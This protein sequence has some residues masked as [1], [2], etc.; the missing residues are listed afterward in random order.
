VISTLLDRLIYAL[1]AE[2]EI[3]VRNFLEQFLLKSERVS[4]EMV[5]LIW[6]RHNS[7]MQNTRRW[8]FAGLY[9]DLALYIQQL[10]VPTIMLWGVGAQF[11]S[12]NLGRRL[13]QLNPQAVRAFDPI[14]GVGVLPHLEMPEVV[15]CYSSIS[16]HC[17]R[18][19]DKSCRNQTIKVDP[20]SPLTEPVEG[21]AENW[22][23]P[24]IC[25]IK[26]LAIANPNPV[27][28]ISELLCTP[29]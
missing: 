21:E 16:G 29:R 1:G 2:N 3:A 20:G 17:C 26:S 8:H 12:V 5:E 15:I 4:Q 10:A 14:A 11:T 28:G 19:V 6:R 22:L 25:S 27:P 23:S 13:A 18:L 7:Q 24:C 9:F